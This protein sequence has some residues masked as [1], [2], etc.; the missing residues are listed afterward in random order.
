MWSEAMRMR[1]GIVCRVLSSLSDSM[2][3]CVSARIASSLINFLQETASA[4]VLWP[5]SIAVCERLDGSVAS[6]TTRSA[7]D[8]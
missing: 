4:T 1:R 6:C 7:L 8:R 5:V 2:V 3:R